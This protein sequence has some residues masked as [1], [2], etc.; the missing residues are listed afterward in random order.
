MAAKTQRKQLILEVWVAHIDINRVD[1]I[2]HFARRI[3]RT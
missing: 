3:N 2:Q 1:T